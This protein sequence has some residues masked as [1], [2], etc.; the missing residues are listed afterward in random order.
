MVK[1][2]NAVSNGT[3]NTYENWSLMLV[4]GANSVMDAPVGGVMI[5]RSVPYVS[6]LPP[7]VV[8]LT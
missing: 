3:R 6:K 8:F 5:H 2:V 1:P 4:S 7:V